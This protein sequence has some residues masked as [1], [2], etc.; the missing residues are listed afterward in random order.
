MYKPEYDKVEKPA[1][2]QLQE[3]GWRFL[4]GEAFSVLGRWGRKTI[5]K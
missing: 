3:L 2:D 4:P 5:T 1:L